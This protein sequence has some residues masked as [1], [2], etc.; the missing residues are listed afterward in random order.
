MQ[1]RITIDKDDYDFIIEKKQG[2]EKEVDKLEDLLRKENKTLMIEA[3]ALAKREADIEIAKA[4]DLNADLRKHID[5]LIETIKSLKVT[6][7]VYEERYN[8][9][10]KYN[11]KSRLHRFFNKIQFI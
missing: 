7:S 8:E 2:L 9:I 5:R 4:N 11:S 3:R 1:P 10:R 6:T